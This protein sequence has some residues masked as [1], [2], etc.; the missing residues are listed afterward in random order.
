[1]LP[2]EVLVIDPLISRQNI[3]PL[4]ETYVDKSAKK[5]IESVA[6]NPS[7]FQ[8]THSKFGNFGYSLRDTVRVRFSLRNPADETVLKLIVFS[9]P[10]TDVAIYTERKAEGLKSIRAAY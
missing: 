7:L 2:G 1:M 5:N 10:V 3:Y 8:P 6:Q 4:A 9:N